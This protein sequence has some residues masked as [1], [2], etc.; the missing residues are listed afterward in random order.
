MALKPV[1]QLLRLAANDRGVLSALQN[2]PVQLRRRLHLSDAHVQAL[3]SAGPV[4]SIS[5]A[6]DLDQSGGMTNLGTLLP[7]EGSGSADPD[8]LP[9][10]P[11]SSSKNSTSSSKSSGSSSKK[12]SSSESSGLSSESSG[13]SS[14]SP[15]SSSESSCPGSKPGCTAPIGA[16]THTC[17]ASVAV[18][19]GGCCC[20]CETA[21]VA[22]VAQ[23]ATTAQTAITAIT[24]IAGM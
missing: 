17:G 24:A 22:I 11:T 16:D 4:S 10:N 1:A 12:G 14:E 21:A 2:D 13:S 23:V 15:G 5:L 18:S 20:P 3:V 19:S 8:E 9:P 6:M 7:P